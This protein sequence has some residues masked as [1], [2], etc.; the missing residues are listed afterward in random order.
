MKC[1]ACEKNVP[2]DAARCPECG[3]HLGQWKMYNTALDQFLHEGAFFACENDL[4]RAALCFF[5][6]VFIAPRNYLA[7]GA[8]GKVLAQQGL[9]DEAIYYLQKAV[10]ATEEGG[11]PDDEENV[12]AALAKAESLKGEAVSRNDVPA[13]A[14][15]SQATSSSADTG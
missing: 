7:L 8:L 4:L 3:D 15:H 9:F 1:I 6:A 12:K 14:D 13:E 11:H 2:E 5:K 10:K